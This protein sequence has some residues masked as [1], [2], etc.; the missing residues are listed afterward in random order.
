MEITVRLAENPE[1]GM[2]KALLGAHADHDFSTLN[3][4]WLVAIVNGVI[5]GCI[6]VRHGRPIGNLDNLAVSSTLRWAHRGL[7]VERLLLEGCAVLRHNGST[8]ASGYVPA[9]LASYQTMLQNRGATVHSAGAMI[10]IGL[11]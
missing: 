6:Q 1:G 4:Y 10:V 11:V 3:P 5:A 9:H 7:V 2:V 8:V